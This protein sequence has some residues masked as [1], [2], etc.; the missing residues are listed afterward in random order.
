MKELEPLDIKDP[1]FTDHQM[2]IIKSMLLEQKAEI[3]KL[4]MDAIRRL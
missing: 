4:M 2:L 3:I 1:A